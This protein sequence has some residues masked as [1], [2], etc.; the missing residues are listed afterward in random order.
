MSGEKKLDA[1]F[2][3]GG[4]KGI[5]LIGAAQVVE[6]AGYSFENLAGTSAGAIVAT[7]LGAGYSSAE[8][9]TILMELDFTK[10]KDTTLIGR[11]PLL[12][13]EIEIIKQWGLYRGDYFLNLM[14]RWLSEKMG[15]EKVTFRD[16]ILPG[17][18][19]DR[20]RFKVHVV[21]SDISRGRMLVL[22]ED[23]RPYGIEPEDLEVALAV[24]MSMSIPFFFKPVTLRNLQARNCYIVDGGLLSNFPIELFDTPPPAPPAWPTF[25]F[26]LV[27]PKSMRSHDE[28]VAHQIHGPASMLWAM[29]GTAMEAHDAF[30]MSQPDVS[31][32]T[33]KI[34]NL[35]IPTT[36]FELSLTQKGELYESG[37]AG[38]REF[39]ATWDFDR[40]K[41]QFRSGDP[42]IRRQAALSMPAASPLRSEPGEESN[43]T[44]RPLPGALST[45]D[46]SARPSQAGPGVS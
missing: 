31:A 7:L 33:I 32:R 21:A 23:I 41:A 20:Y 5:A 9:K 34:D 22:P 42:K 3:G 11:I 4:V 16:L 39:L 8:L 46:S 13:P 38:A 18:S 40:Y 36:A 2:E 37:Q 25:G 29:F 12:G 27:P 45:T 24:R 35:G 14:R 6:D 28:A 30:Y 26:C 1:V 44:G 10:F 43:P 19:E 17:S 15:K